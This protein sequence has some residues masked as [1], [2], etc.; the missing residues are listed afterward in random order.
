VVGV[1]DESG[2]L[3]AVEGSIR[4]ITDRF[5]AQQERDR[6]TEQLRR[7]ER[8]EALGN[9]AGGIAHDFNNLLEVI[10]GHSDLLLTALPADS[11][12]RPRLESIRQAAERGA[13]LT[14]QLRVFSHT[15]PSKPETLDLNTVVAD[16][17]RLLE[18][19]LSEDIEFTTRLAA[20]TCPVLVDRGRF[21]RVLLNLVTNARQA[22]PH[23]GRLLIE[24]DAVPAADG[25]GDA[26]RLRVTD[27]GRG[28]TADVLQH[29]FEP[30][31]TTKGRGGGGGFGLS[32]AYGTVTDAGGEITLESE[33]GTGTVVTITLPAADGAVTA[34]PSAAGPAEAGGGETVLLVEDDP[35]VRE[36]VGLMLRGS[37]YLSTVASSP[38]AALDLL[39]RDAV[40]PDLLLTDVVMPGMTGIELAE[41]LRRTRPALPVLLIS[42]HTADTLPSDAA[43]PAL[44]SLLRK[45][46]TSTGLRHAIADLLARPA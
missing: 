32:T 16:I 37:G 45:P 22:M 12:V 20:G 14:G 15:G 27:T 33:P 26:V 21:E 40:A 3:V 36:L 23:G 25:G 46:F 17:E 28:M 30:F 41:R 29:A 11:P 42:G 10:L 24:T 6:L 18:H 34:A 39:A 5:R 19:T 8:M 2:R 38:A 4:D 13:D 43:L 9:L 35:D 7:A 44:T 31:F 1:H